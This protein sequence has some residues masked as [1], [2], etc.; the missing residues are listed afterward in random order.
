LAARAL[1]GLDPNV[2]LPVRDRV[3]FLKEGQ[4]Y[5]PGARAIAGMQDEII[6]RTAGLALIG[7]PKPGCHARKLGREGAIR[8]RN[9]VVK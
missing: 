1:Y 3:V 4:E 5:P 7:P 6:N 9:P 8:V 2:L